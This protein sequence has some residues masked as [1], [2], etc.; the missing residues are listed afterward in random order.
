[1]NGIEPTPK[2][3]LFHRA[4]AEFD[5]VLF[6]GARGPGKSFA[7]CHEALRQSLDYPGNVGVI[8]RKDLVDLRDTTEE[9]M[10][11]YVLPAYVEDGLR[12]K[13]E[14][15]GRPT[16]KVFARSVA[17][18]ILWRDAKDEGSLMSGNLGWAAIDEAVET[19]ENFYLAIRGATGRCKIPD[20]R[21]APRRFF[22]GSNPGPGW[23][24]R[25][26][27]VGSVAKKRSATITDRDGQTRQIVRAFIPAL[28]RDNPHLPA[29]YE[30]QL[31]Q[32]YP[33]A[34][35]R[36]FIEG[37]WDVFEGQIYTEFNE[38]RHVRAFDIPRPG[39]WR[40]LAA[41]DWGYV[42]PCS[43][44]F[45]GVDGEDHVWVW[46][47]HYRSG[48]RPSQHAEVLKPRLMSRGIQSVLAGPDAWGREKD[49]TTVASEFAGAGVMLVR[50]NNEVAG[51]IQFNKRLLADDRVTFHPECVN[52]IREIKEYQWAPQTASQSESGDPR[53]QPVKRNDHAVDDWRYAGNEIRYGGKKRPDEVPVDAKAVWAGMM[54]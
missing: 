9:V 39:T 45:Y 21:Q 40:E 53:E 50:A 38:E 51:G 43:V 23:V 33:D 2:Q 41:M 25:S 29:D 27:P 1:M 26:F 42:N 22:C 18:T 15:G 30:A 16:L 31:R 8:A 10:R 19:S 36:R 32:I 34:W 47:E 35:V 52:L 49:G 11:R 14:G 20:G 3:L 7:I 13:W 28:P 24:R 46:G 5:E 17:S 54:G 48:W 6:G 4:V 37:S 12:V 44:H